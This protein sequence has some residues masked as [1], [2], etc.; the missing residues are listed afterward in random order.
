MNE[1]VTKVIIDREICKGCGLCAEVCPHTLIYIALDEINAKG[2]QPAVFVD[3]EGNCT[4][5]ALCATVCPDIAITVYAEE[6]QKS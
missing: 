6:K 4:S 5:C 2:Y 3:P 1:I